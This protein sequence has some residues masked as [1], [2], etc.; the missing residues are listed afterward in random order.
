[1]LVVNAEGYLA[2]R[3]RTDV[4][5][6]AKTQ[7]QIVLR[8]KPKNSSVV[9]RAKA[10]QIKQKIQFKTNSD[11]IDPVSFNLCDEIAAVIVEHAE[12]KQVEIQGHTDDRGKRD[13]NIDL[14]ERRA[15][16]VR[17]YLV[18]AGVESSRLTAKGFGPDKP[19]APNITTGG[20]AK[21]RRVEFVILDKTE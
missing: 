13:Y 2:K 14:S 8:E 6:G 9:V 1:M 7:V 11:E 15:S 19:L 20:R 17:R 10:I 16:S 5:A 12:L 21:N 4:K 3:I 18:D